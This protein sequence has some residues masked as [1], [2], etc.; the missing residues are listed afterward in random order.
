[1]T[2]SIVARDPE[3]GDLGVAVQSHYF[4]TGTVVT[5]AQAGVGA[6]ATQSIP[7]VSYGPKGLDLMRSGVSADQALAQLVSV[8]PMEMVRQVAMVDAMGRTGTHTGAGCVGKAGHLAGNQVSVQ[9]NM[10]ERDTVWAA[11]IEAYDGASGA[12]LAERLLLALE[13]AEAE[14]GDVRGRQ[15]A[16]LLIVSGPLTD[17]PWD[18]KKFDLRVDDA[19]VPLAEL[20]RLVSTNRAVHRLTEV[21]GSGILFSPHL[22]PDSPELAG[23][24]EALDAAQAGL[25]PNRE[26]TFW[27]AALLAKAGRLDEARARLA[28]A[29]ET[30][31]RWGTF[32]KSI[33]AAG[34]LPI[35]NPLV[36][37]G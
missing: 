37:G 29:S 32:L 7:Q 12:D 9:A 4:G 31:P 14:G 30:N 21:F 23:A 34:V 11:M 8:D 6:V 24:I 17:A 36:T 26:P 10:M 16:A 18:Q 33:A 27:S 15:S 1:M 28:F 25:G 19:E 13:A 2:Y 22:A 35:D 3:T 20:R 5:W